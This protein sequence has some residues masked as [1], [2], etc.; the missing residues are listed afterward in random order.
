MSNTTIW[1]IIIG[2]GLIT[3]L[4]RLSF[5]LI[6]G[7]RKMPPLLERSL[8]FTPP[9]VLSALVLPAFLYNDGVLD[10]SLGNIRMLAGF[11]AALV[12]WRTGNILLTIVVGMVALW[13]MTFLGM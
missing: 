13:G 10:F 5:L 1:I 7:K 9:A 8:R 4:E 12:A 6:L 3:Y 11:I 2:M